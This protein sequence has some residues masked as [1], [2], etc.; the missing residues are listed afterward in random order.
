[1]TTSKPAA[2]AVA[3][4]HGRDDLGALPELSSGRVVRAGDA[5]VEVGG[6]GATARLEHEPVHPRELA[7]RLLESAHDLE[8]PLQCLL[9]LVRVQLGDVL[10][11]DRLVDARVVLH[12]ARPEEAHAHHPERLLREMEVVPQHL[13]LR[14]L[15]Q[16]GRLL[17]QHR[18]RDERLRVPDLGLELRLDGRD[19]DA[20]R[21]GPAELHHEGLVPDGGVVAA[22]RG[23]RVTSSSAVT[24]R[25]TSARVCASV[26][27]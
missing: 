5:R 23:H 12:R 21:A 15:R 18:R 19:L 22:K 3:A 7:E 9:A 24:S 20:A 11:H 27:Q 17:A 6:V 10:L 16:I 4:L 8:D 26:T 13:G 14:Q 1:V 2:A 25:S